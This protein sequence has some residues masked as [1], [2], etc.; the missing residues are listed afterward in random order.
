MNKDQL[1]LS[2]RESGTFYFKHFKV[3]DSRSTMK[4][5]TDAVLL[6]ASVE[7]AT[8]QNILEIGT[9]CGVIALMLA[10]RCNALIDAIDIDEA[11]AGQAR[12]N[13]LGS[14]WA[15]RIQVI[16][17]SLQDYTAVTNTRY[18]LIV[19]NPPYFSNSL[20][21]P[22]NKKN[23]TRHNDAL[24]PSELAICS[25]K[26][27]NESASLWLILPVKESDEFIITAL[28]TGL[29]V[30]AKT[31]IFTI[32]G[33]SHTRNILRFMK[34]PDSEAKPGQLVIKNKENQYTDEY[35]SLT[36]EFYLDF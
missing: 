17:S 15:D 26:L 29:K 35:K 33:R 11:S 3:E 2:G 32:A 6:G 21:S 18:D 27:M 8:A 7:T 19:A 16:H 5:G 24:S 14:P 22:S 1:K 30:R 31:R 4:V 34:N 10:Q 23:L 9:G 12:E 13:V 36:G 20:K 28:E 25:A